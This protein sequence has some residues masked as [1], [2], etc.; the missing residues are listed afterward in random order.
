MKFTSVKAVVVDG[1][2]VWKLT[3]EVA[4]KTKKGVSIKTYRS[5]ENY[6]SEQEALAALAPKKR[7]EKND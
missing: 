5:V 2:E 6:A 3:K 7:K 1:G 4:R